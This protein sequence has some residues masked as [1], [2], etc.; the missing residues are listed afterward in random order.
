M[1]GSF[2]PREGLSLLV[3]QFLVIATNLPESTSLIY[4]QPI[5]SPYSPCPKS[6]PEPG[7]TQ[8]E[9]IPITQSYNKLFK[10]FNPTL[11]HPCSKVGLPHPFLST[12]TTI[13]APAH[14]SPLL[15][16]PSDQLW[17]FPIWPCVACH[18]LQ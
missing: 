9:T 15:L 17:C 4:N 7:T 1:A 6:P 12:E 5:Q 3:T 14:V 13:K 16:L 2:A 11:A 10:L 18:G 8:L